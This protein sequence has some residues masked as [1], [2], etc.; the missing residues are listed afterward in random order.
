VLRGNLLFQA[1]PVPAGT[2][3]VELRYQPARLAVGGAISGLALLLALVGLSGLSLPWPR[4]FTR[5]R[6]ARWP[7]P[8]AAGAG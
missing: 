5:W 8:R 2:H 6:L 3:T 4:A 1:V 7:R